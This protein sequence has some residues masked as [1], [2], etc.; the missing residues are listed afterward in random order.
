MDILLR[1]C[2]SILSEVCT[3]KQPR[4]G[5]EKE[6]KR[7]DLMSASVVL[8]LADTVSVLQA[9]SL[10]LSVLFRSSSLLLG[11]PPFY[12]LRRLC[13]LFLLLQ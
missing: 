5:G 3:V 10:H 6:G 13:S 11:A 9:S 8:A 7:K 2:F 12:I 4:E 1:R